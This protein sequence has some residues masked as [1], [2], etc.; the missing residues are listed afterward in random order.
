MKRLPEVRFKNRM[1]AGQQLAEELLQYKKDHPLILA[2]PR[3]GVPVGY[4]VA[5]VLEAPLDTVVSRKIGAPFSPEFGVGAIAPG[6]VIIFDDASI[7]ALGLSKRHLDPVIEAETKEMHRRMIRYKSGE[8]S[9]GFQTDT[10]IIVDDGLATGVTARAAI[11]SVKINSKPKKLIFASPIC[12]LSSAEQLRDQVDQV[13]CKGEVGDL[14]AVGYWYED[15]PQT[16][17]EEV[18]QYLEKANPSL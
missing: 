16:T 15:F 8:Y 9:R 1:D 18:M 4:E 11:E 12:A 6:N 2:L 10:L 3:G 17:D 5:R 7:D 14:M 13:V